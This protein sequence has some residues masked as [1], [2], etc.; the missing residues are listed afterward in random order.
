[1]N[2]L[3]NKRLGIAMGALLL[4]GVGVGAGIVVAP[5][6]DGAGGETAEGG[7]EREI[8]YWYD[9][10]VPNERYPGPG[11]SSMNMETI[12]K[13]ADEGGT[14]ATPGVRIDPA[15]AQN[16]G[17]RY[18]T[19]RRGDLEGD[20]SATAVV[21]YNER[22]IAVVQSRADGFVQRVYNRA[23]GD[24]IAAGAPLVDLLIPT[25][26]GAQTEY[27]AVRRTGNTPLIQ[28]ARQ[29]LVLMGMS[30]SLIA[31]VERSGRARNTITISTPTGGVIKT[32]G[33]RAGMS[34]TQ[35]MT[36]AEINGLATVWVNAAIPEALGSRLRVGQSV[37]VALTAFP[38]ERFTGRLTALLPELVG[39]SRTV[40]G[41]I[42]M[43][44]RGGRLRPG[45]FGR[46]TFGGG[47]T[48]ALLVPTEAV[49]RTG[50]RDI[51]ML[52]RPEGR[53]QPAEVRVGRE[54]GGQTEILAGLREG[55]R[56]VA[57]GQFLI[58]SEASLS[59]VTARPIGP[60]SR[61]ATAAPTG[62]SMAAPAS[63]GRSSQ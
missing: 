18:A 17:V 59:G 36:L 53:Y 46:I 51:V 31:S 48:T 34:V 19:A 37:E 58:D 21:D 29:R 9:P 44:N 14:T 55:E 4:V 25:W 5:R 20:L 61:P 50:E 38:G 13:Y 57:S 63:R 8:L 35:G 3:R 22:D 45:M 26:G 23:P 15:L 24:V 11:K 54:A 56:I 40:T 28:A 27:L 6:L 30:E 1:M 39:D 43:A 52:A 47:S 60:T 32:L 16:L 41:R 62:A 33:V 10:M 12:P 42:E 2:A 49:I 7:G